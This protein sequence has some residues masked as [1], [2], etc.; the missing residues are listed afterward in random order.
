M[1]LHKPIEGGG[2]NMKEE[3][4]KKSFMEQMATLIV[5]KRKGLFL[6]FAIAI[7]FCVIAST[8]VKVDDDI[9]DY[10]PDSTQTRQGLTIMDDEFVTYG[11][12]KIMVD[13]VS[14]EKAQQIAKV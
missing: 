6:A 8:W 10:L 2:Y 13:N 5:D 12:A 7:I 3:E 9:T 1:I 11:S 14:Y 4:E